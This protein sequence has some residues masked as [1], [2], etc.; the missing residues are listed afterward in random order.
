MTRF[1]VRTELLLGGTWTDITDRVY[2]RD[3]ISIRRGRS[4]ESARVDPG[5]CSLTL[6]NRDGNFSPRNPTGAYYGLL[7]RNTPLRVW[8]G[9]PFT[10]AADFV[11]TP[12]AD[13]STDVDHIAPSVMSRGDTG[14]LLCTWITGFDPGTYTVPASM[15]A[16]P[17]TDG[18]DSSMIVAVEE[19][20][21]PGDTGTRTATFAGGDVHGHAQA[22]ITIPGNSV[23]PVVE[24]IVFEESDGGYITLRT[25]DTVQAGWWLVAIHAWDFDPD[26][27]MIA[28]PAGVTP[29]HWTPL[30]DSR[31]TTA[32][33]PHIKSWARPV[34]QS[35]AQEVIF[36]SD[37][38]RQPNNHARIYV[39]S[40]VDFASIRFSGEVA[41]W[42]PRWDVSGVDV[43]VR[44]EAAG[45]LRRL[46][47][48][49]KQIRSAIYRET[50]SAR[51]QPMAYWPCEDGSNADSLASGVDHGSPL[52]IQGEPELASY[53]GF[54][55]SEPLPVI[56]QARLLGTVLGYVPTGETQIRWLMHVPDE[57]ATDTQ[58]IIT[59]YT[60]TGLRWTVRYRTAGTGTLN[61]RCFELT[62]DDYAL[63][64]D[65]DY[66]F[67]VNGKDLRVAWEFTQNGSNI[68]YRVGTVE[69][70]AAT[71]F[72]D[73][74]TV[75]GRS[76]GAVQRVTMAIRQNLGDVALGHIS[77]HAEI[78]SMFDL[79]DAL[80][81]HRGE[82]AGRR[83]ERL[84]RE[85]GI[86][87]RA[88]GGLNDTARMGPQGVV[89]LVGLFSEAQ[90]ADGG[91]L[92]ETREDIGL[93]YRTRASLYNQQSPS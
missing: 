22:S 48:G 41:A 39:L 83:I 26:D 3:P 54:A 61:V 4:N 77:V 86:A 8:A 76:M 79:G 12:V 60:S 74:A 64:H 69:P 9:T 5:S 47:Q 19:L 49:N 87:I 43:H 93:T 38:N 24:E 58:Q 40:G 29:G 53:D 75:T 15:T 36:V 72:G 50:V 14:L 21:T 30:A 59:I 25:S 18:A 11:D 71:G 17:Q 55:G 44:V 92:Y 85:E 37:N 10:G 35:G 66:A 13:A 80:D 89:S 46:G 2:Q 16:G 84:C 33:G 65:T 82:K 28:A 51:R 62:D 32:R 78:T 70:G 88:V 63:I 91:A 34:V 1:Q 73:G 20:A 45:I 6:D 23:A 42:P 57:G 27:T 31:E 52:T 81:A 68:D 56:K 7:G 90:D 67:S